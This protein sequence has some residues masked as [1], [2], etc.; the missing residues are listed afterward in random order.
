MRSLPEPVRRFLNFSFTDPS[1]N[2]KQPKQSDHSRTTQLQSD[3]LSLLKGDNAKARKLL[4]QERKI[5]SGMSNAWYL[6][7]I[8]DDLRRDR[9]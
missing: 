4:E 6:E 2:R 7:K 8:V 9:H 5:R 3:L 1:A